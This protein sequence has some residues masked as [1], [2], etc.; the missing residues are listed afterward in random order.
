MKLPV[1]VVI[2]TRNEGRNL[3]QCLSALD[4]FQHVVVVDSAST[5]HAMNGSTCS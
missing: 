2:P 3:P 4:E 5:G 1:T